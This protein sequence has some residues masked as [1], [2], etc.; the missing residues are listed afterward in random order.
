[1]YEY[2]A[3]RIDTFAQADNIQPTLNSYA[4]R[5]WRLFSITNTLTFVTN[6]GGD[7]V[8]GATQ[9]DFLLLVFEREVSE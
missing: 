4:S 6:E 5:G 3:E 9:S 7:A 2:A 8:P 1:M